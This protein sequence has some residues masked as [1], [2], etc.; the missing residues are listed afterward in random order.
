M[1]QICKVFNL[2]HTI[3]AIFYEHKEVN[4]SITT[5]VVAVFKGRLDSVNPEAYYNRATVYSAIGEKK[6][7]EK[8]LKIY[9]LLK[10]QNKN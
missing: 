4:L 10:S 7:M 3:S 6:K 5:R 2:F 9:Q 1:W 8:D